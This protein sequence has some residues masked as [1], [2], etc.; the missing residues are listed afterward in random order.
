MTHK[1]KVC[2]RLIDIPYDAIGFFCHTSCSIAPSYGLTVISISCTPIEWLVST[3]VGIEIVTD[4][5]MFSLLVLLLLDF[6]VNL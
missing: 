5:F 6:S 1:T 4:V 2:A 3:L